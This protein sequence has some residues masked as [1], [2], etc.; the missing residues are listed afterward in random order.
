[1]KKKL[2]MFLTAGLFALLIGLSVVETG[3]ASTPLKDAIGNTL[4]TSDIQTYGEVVGEAG[5]YAYCYYKNNPKYAKEIAR[6]EEIWAAIEKA[7]IEGGRENLDLAAI[8]DATCQ[9]ITLAATTELGPANGALVGAGARAALLLGYQFYKSR[10]KD[11]QLEVYLNA[12]W[13]GVEKAKKNGVLTI[14]EPTEVDKLVSLE[15]SEECGIECVIDKVRS[16][17]AAG[18]LTNYDEKRLKARLKELNKR[19]EQMMAEIE[20]EIEAERQRL[21]K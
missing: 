8:N 16:R 3:C 19:Y 17:L 1:M 11:D 13:T 9:I 14:A 18:G 21:N 10:M 12:V 15:P 20:A 4:S 6:I 5:Y 7:K 2:S